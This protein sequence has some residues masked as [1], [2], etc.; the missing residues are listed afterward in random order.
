MSYRTY[1]RSVDSGTLNKAYNRLSFRSN[2][3][4]YFSGTVSDDKSIDNDASDL[5]LTYMGTSS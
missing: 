4:N 1:D 2:N 5:H 3:Q